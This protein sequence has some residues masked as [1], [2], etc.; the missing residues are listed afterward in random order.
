MPWASFIG[1]VTVGA[2]IMST[3]YMLGR[4]GCSSAWIVVLVALSFLKHKLWKSRE[5]RL[6][7]LR[8]TALRE[9][10][11]IVAQLADLPAWVNFRDTERVEWVNKVRELFSTS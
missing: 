10:E 7:A 8:Q 11:V 1:T 3:C 5:K 4:C 2:V 9:K 6:M